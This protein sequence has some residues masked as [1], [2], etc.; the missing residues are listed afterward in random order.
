MYL[1]YKN[2][3]QMYLVNENIVIKTWNRFFTLKEDKE[4]F[5]MIKR[6]INAVRTPVTYEKILSALGDEKKKIDKAISVLLKTNVIM[7]AEDPSLFENKYLYHYEN[8]LL[9]VENMKNKAVQV[10]D[11]P[12]EIRKLLQDEGMKLSGEA[13]DFALVWNSGS[14]ADISESAFAGRAERTI[15]CGIEKGTY[16]MII[17]D[18][19]TNDIRK[20]GYYFKNLESEKTN[21][22]QK[23]IFNEVLVNTCIRT[24]FAGGDSDF[25]TVSPDLSVKK[26]NLNFHMIEASNKERKLTEADVAGETKEV[27]YPDFDAFVNDLPF[28]GYF[29]SMNRDQLPIPKQELWLIDK[30]GNVTDKILSAGDKCETAMR[31]AFGEAMNRFLGENFRIFDDKNTYYFNLLT[32]KLFETDN[33]HFPLESGLAEDGIKISCY[34]HSIFKIGKVFVGT[35]EKRVSFNN[36]RGKTLKQE[37]SYALIEIGCPVNRAIEL[38]EKVSGSVSGLDEAEDIEALN[39]RLLSYLTDIGTGVYEVFNEYSEILREQ[40]IYLGRLK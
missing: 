21:D 5:E 20:A 40:G 7:A 9:I 18:E 6:V 25:I 16:Y 28:V 23:I 8:P 27:L 3:I 35:G 12:E 33:L 4:T 39:K 30:S 31:K 37:I 24:F 17:G 32:D 10:K 26:E 2:N 13:G 22:N 1:V 11:V 14:L 19:S 15:V 29:G 38:S 36:C 34:I